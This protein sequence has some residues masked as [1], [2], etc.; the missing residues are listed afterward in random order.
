MRVSKIIAAPFNLKP[1]QLS[2]PIPHP[3][4]RIS[5]AVYDGKIS[6]QHFRHISIWADV[7]P[8]DVPRSLR[9]FLRSTACC[10]YTNSS[11]WV[12]I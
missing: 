10:S 9:S 2:D 6:R 12:L 7:K 1:G 11:L 4:L 5:H 8:S 3:Q